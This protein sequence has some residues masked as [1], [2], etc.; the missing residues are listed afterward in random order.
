MEILRVPDPFPGIEDHGR[1]LPEEE[2]VPGTDPRD[3]W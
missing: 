2:L 1:G 3:H